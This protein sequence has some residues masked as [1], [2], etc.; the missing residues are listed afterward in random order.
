MMDIS[1][2]PAGAARCARLTMR[3]DMAFL[4]ETRIFATE[5]AREARLGDERTFDLKVAISEACANAVEH[6]S[7]TEGKAELCAWLY[8]DRLT[9]EVTSPGPFL[10]RSAME[11][12][13]RQHRGMGLP[14]MVAL[15]DEVAIRRGENGAMVVALTIYRHPAEAEAD[16]QEAPGEPD[17]LARERRLTAQLAHEADTREYELSATF[18]A[19]ADPVMIFDE[20]QRVVRANA[21]ALEQ[22]AFDPVGLSRPEIHSKLRFRN[23]RGEPLPV[24]ELPSARAAAGEQVRGV[25]LLLGNPLG[26]DYLVEASASPLVVDGQLQGAVVAWR[27]VTKQE[28]LAGERR[29]A[30]RLAEALNE[31]NLRISATLERDQILSCIVELAA[32]ALRTQ[33]ATVLLRQGDSWTLAH[34]HGLPAKLMGVALTVEE[35]PIAALAVRSRRAVAVEDALTDERLKGRAMARLRIRAT[36]VAPF[37]CRNE[38]SGLIAFN[39]H[40]GPRRFNEVEVDFAEKLAATVSAALENALLLEERR[41]A[42]AL[43]MTL[44]RLNAAIL[45]STLDPGE[46]MDRVLHEA[47]EAMGC[48]TAAITMREGDMWMVRYSYGF[49]PPIVGDVLTDEEAPHGVLAAR[50]Q[51]AVVVNDARHDPRV[52]LRVIEHYGIRSVL[53]LPLVV[54][55]GVVGVMY[56]N[57]H[58]A[59]VPFP[60][61]KV[62]LGVRVAA[63]VSV[64]LENARLYLTE[65]SM[66]RTLQTALLTVPPRARG[67][68]FSHLHRS[69]T[70]HAEIGGDFYDLFSL[71]DERLGLLIGDVSGKGIKGAAMAALVKNLVKAYA[72]RTRSP[73]RAMSQANRVA[74]LN[75]PPGGFTTAFLAVLELPTGRLTY[76]NAGHPPPALLRGGQPAQL[77]PTG[78]P[79]LGSLVA[80]RFQQHEDELH[81]GDRLLLYTDGATEARRP[82]AEGPIFF[83]EEGLLRAVEDLREVPVTEL[84]R[85]L[86]ERVLAFG[87]GQLTDDIALLCVSLKSGRGG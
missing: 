7:H 3:Q 19:L 13:Q 42:H 51:Q 43:A 63:S 30:S 67:V 72:Y 22:L 47:A 16:V 23:L 45:A 25:R 36:L 29:E 38:I 83:G 55:S 32:E 68:E 70:V 77:L 60:P 54:K 56:F 35:T 34:A 59:A 9:V 76:C 39:E 65:L 64:A 53:V 28:A 5:V 10:L 40:T 26:A 1:W 80:A 41:Q 11:S 20:E 61:A 66:A 14:L 57:Y 50:T 2:E 78:S 48:E 15:V 58:S 75:L 49:D 37:F 87:A 8:S 4:A 86:Y 85:R 84:P 33:T 6:S 62:D 18:D 21:A 24:D 12:E 74:L 73:A 44:S 17:L 81:P 31:I 27:D 71:D 79:V 52:E 82:A 69:A 46:I